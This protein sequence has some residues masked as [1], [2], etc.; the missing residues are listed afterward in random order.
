MK[1]LNL[2]YMHDTFENYIQKSIN[3]RLEHM[4]TILAIG[5]D[6]KCVGCINTYI[7][8]I[9]TY[10]RPGEGVHRL[11]LMNKNDI[12]SCSA[13]R[14]TYSKAINYFVFNEIKYPII[15]LGIDNLFL[16]QEYCNNDNTFSSGCY[17]F[18]NSFII[19]IKYNII[20]KDTLP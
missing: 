11:K 9:R 19:D 18:S 20:Y 14:C 6:L 16:K 13:Y 10:S 3:E 17:D 15:L 12:D 1:P 4:D 7:P 8:K 2:F 5:L